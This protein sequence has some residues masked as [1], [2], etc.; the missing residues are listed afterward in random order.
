MFHRFVCP[1]PDTGFNSIWYRM[2]AFVGHDVACLGVGI[3]D[4]AAIGLLVGC[5]HAAASPKKLRYLR[6]AAVGVAFTA[7]LPFVGAVA[8]IGHRVLSELTRSGWA[9]EL[10]N[11]YLARH[12]VCCFVILVLGACAAASP[13][14]AVALSACRLRLAKEQQ[15]LDLRQL[16]KWALTGAAPVA[17]Q[18]LWVTWDVGSGRVGWA[19]ACLWVKRSYYTASPL[20]M[21]MAGL[22][23]LALPAAAIAA[24]VVPVRA[25]TRSMRLRRPPAPSFTDPSRFTA[26]YSAPPSPQITL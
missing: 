2:H 26:P 10:F 6:N 23:L 8:V 5:V 17:A 13:A 3:S 7:S 15:D 14:V 24:L 16:Q 20:G 21:F 9:T 19:L 18:L 12:F 4:L 1:P 11:P 25:A 22:I